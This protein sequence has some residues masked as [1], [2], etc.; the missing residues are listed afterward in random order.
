[1]LH[2]AFLIFST[3]VPQNA[4][5]ANVKLLS[6]IAYS[7]RKQIIGSTFAARRAGT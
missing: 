2:A 6:E 7:Y 4:L 3:L 1:L 5:I